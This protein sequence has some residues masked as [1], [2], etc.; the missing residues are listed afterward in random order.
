[1]RDTRARPRRPVNATGLDEPHEGMQDPL[2]RLSS[3]M[4][5]CD[6]SDD[7]A[8][9]RGGA[10][11]I[12]PAFMV[13]AAC[14]VGLA[15]PG[16]AQEGA[17]PPAEAGRAERRAPARASVDELLARLANAVDPG[18]AAAIRTR[19][20][21]ARLASGS[22]SVDLLVARAITLRASG[23]ADGAVVLLDAVVG[24]EPRWASGLKLRGTVRLGRG[25]F[26]AAEIDLL[27]ALDLEPR[28]PGLLDMVAALAVRA[29]RPAE[30]LARLRAAVALDPMEAGRAALV[31]KLSIAVEGRE[32]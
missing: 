3:L 27:A 10:R 29:G 23:D 16:L 6:L 1:M 26:A 14:L 18:E 30:A 2:M 19:L 25:D 28:D 9:A 12:L 20:D 21:A 4:T 5:L 24:L 17:R 15:V 22:A 31:E 32:L 7:L 13:A 8:T 11:Q